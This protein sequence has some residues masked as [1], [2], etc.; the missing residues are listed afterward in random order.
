MG[1][2]TPDLYKQARLDALIDMVS[3]GT[4]SPALA[5][6]L[7]CLL[8]RCDGRVHI[9]SPSLRADAAELASLAGS[10]ATAREA[11]LYI[12]DCTSASNHARAKAAA[13]LLDCFRNKVALDLYDAVLQDEAL[14]HVPEFLPQ[15]QMTPSDVDADA[16]ICALPWGA[17]AVALL[18]TPPPADLVPPGQAP[19]RDGHVARP[20]HHSLGSV[21]PSFGGGGE[22]L[23]AQEPLVQ[24]QQPAEHHAV[25]RGCARR[26]SSA[27]HLESRAKAVGDTMCPLPF[28]VPVPLH[29]TSTRWADDEPSG[30]V[31]PAPSAPVSS[32]AL[33]RSSPRRRHAAPPNQRRANLSAGL[34]PPEPV[35]VVSTL[36]PRTAALAA[37]DDLLRSFGEACGGEEDPTNA[38]AAPPA[39]NDL[40]LGEFD[41]LLMELPPCLPPA[42]SAR[43]E[44]A[45]TW[46]PAKSRKGSAKTKASRRAAKSK[47]STVDRA[48][49]SKHSQT[50][51]SCSTISPRVPGLEVEQVAEPEVNTS[52]SSTD[53]K[54]AVLQ[55]TDSQ[56]FAQIVAAAEVQS[57]MD[58][59]YVQR[60]RSNHPRP[61][62]SATDD[63]RVPGGTTKTTVASEFAPSAP[64][65]AR[66]TLKD[67]ASSA[68]KVQGAKRSEKE[69]RSAAGRV[70]PA[71]SQL[72]PAASKRKRPN[73]ANA[74]AVKP[75]AATSGASR[76]PK[77]MKKP[78]LISDKTSEAKANAHSGKK[79]ASS[80]KTSEP[81]MEA[82]PA[83]ESPL[84][85]VAVRSLADAV[86][87]PC[88]APP[89]ATAQARA[90]SAEAETSER[91]DVKD[92]PPADE[93]PPD[94]PISSQNNP[95]GFRGVYPARGSRWQ[96]QVNHRSIGGFPTAWEAGV[97]VARELYDKRMAAKAKSKSKKGRRH[98]AGKKRK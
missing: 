97:A 66:E 1:D 65:A 87:A 20:S 17:S 71:S 93:P 12:A 57:A 94:K 23:H 74:P 8:P 16:E 67:A 78:E 89:T 49:T 9:A 58:A 68:A 3:G 96:A 42:L 38:V 76:L 48:P 39:A 15:L 90:S 28:N 40:D 98:A 13:L 59:P 7:A 95:S 56:A 37:G 62:S 63:A 34:V 52:L 55:T 61:D 50:A 11:V 31:C 60:C 35:D 70:A 32:S 4:Q 26:D 80:L 10:C 72:A 82:A 54:N 14:P 45:P 41:H 24:D 5:L 91:D 33:L 18:P 64:S 83:A 88:A 27:A 47:R 73:A 19:A 75:A 36:L 84:S 2:G 43:S 81:S 44:T 29:A 53:S 92:P 77:N 30:V 46:S 86:A 69:V 25:A 6:V 51:A 85:S 22:Q 21:M 79:S